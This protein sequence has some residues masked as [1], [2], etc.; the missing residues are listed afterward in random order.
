[1][2]TAW[3]V[4]TGH[5]EGNGDQYFSMTSSKKPSKSHKQSRGPVVETSIHFLRNSLITKHTIKS[6]MKKNQRFYQWSATA[7]A[8]LNG[9]T[10][11]VSCLVIHPVGKIYFQFGTPERSWS[12][13]QKDYNICLIIVGLVEYNSRGI[14]FSDTIPDAHLNL[15]FWWMLNS[16]WKREV[17]LL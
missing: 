11:E 14:G 8:M 6:L 17:C 15:K 5:T 12:S 7:G 4:V 10:W 13:C 9:V 2:A 1:M 3:V 16:S